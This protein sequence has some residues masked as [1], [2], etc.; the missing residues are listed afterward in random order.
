LPNVWWEPTTRTLRAVS[1]SKRRRTF[2]ALKP[3]N[4][5]R[6]LN[7][8]REKPMASLKDVESVADNLT[9]LVDELRSELQDTADFDRLTELADQISGEASNAAETFSTVNEA[10]MSRINDLKD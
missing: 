1:A 10:L 3:G 8:R 7:P 6:T 5:A 9:S 2:D 4:V